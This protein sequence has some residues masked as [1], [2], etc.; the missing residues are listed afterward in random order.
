[1]KKILI[2][3]LIFVLFSFTVSAEKIILPEWFSSSLNISDMEIS[4]PRDITI[5]RGTTLYQEMSI[6]NKYISD[7]NVKMFIVED[8]SHY[9]SFSGS[10]VVVM[11]L[12]KTLESKKFVPFTITIPKDS[13]LGEYDAYFNITSNK[14]SSILYPVKINIVEKS[15]FII[16]FFVIAITIFILFAFS[17][18]KKRGKK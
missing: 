1:M 7:I 2:F 14:G 18:R 8:N 4:T 17:S 16:I 13:P 11:T 5:Q 15:N 9:I 6:T 12:E 3:A 10:D